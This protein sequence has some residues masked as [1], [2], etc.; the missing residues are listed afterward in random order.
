VEVEGVEGGDA[1]VGEGSERQDF[2]CAAL[3]GG[4]L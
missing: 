2:Y 3:L 4:I 1:A